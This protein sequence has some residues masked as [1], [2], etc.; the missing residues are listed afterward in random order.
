MLS[1]ALSLDATKAEEIACRPQVEKYDGC[2]VS[3]LYAQT[4]HEIRSFE[5]SE[6][7]GDQSMTQERFQNMVDLD[8]MPMAKRAGADWMFCDGPPIHSRAPEASEVAQDYLDGI[9]EP[10]GVRCA[11]YP[12]KGPDISWWENG[13]FLVKW[14]TKVGIDHM[15]IKNPKL[16]VTRAVII[17]AT[18]CAIKGINSSRR[19]LRKFRNIMLA[20]P[21]RL[22]E[23]KANRGGRVK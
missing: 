14:Y 22:R 18:D 8:V 11:L 7:D 17:L 3:F 2:K 19:E 20:H 9:L 13:I 23:C 6:I 10:Y 4:W 15:L 1:S 21:R 5:I 16:K 12:P